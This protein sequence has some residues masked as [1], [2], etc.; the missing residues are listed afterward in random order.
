MAR[1][2]GVTGLLKTAHHVSLILKPF[3]S[4]H[5]LPQW[6]W[7]WGWGEIKQSPFT[8]YA[9]EETKSNIYLRYHPFKKN[10][11]SI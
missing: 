2:E 11:I 9:S 5:E 3:P 6:N 1:R 10:P 4:S 8:L 7:G